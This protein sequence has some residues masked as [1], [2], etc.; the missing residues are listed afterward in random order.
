[1]LD[2]YNNV[3][4]VFLG[5]KTNKKKKKKRRK[6][7]LT[8]LGLYYRNKSQSQA[9]AVTTNTIPGLLTNERNLFFENRILTKTLPRHRGE[10]EPTRKFINKLAWSQQKVHKINKRLL[11]DEDDPVRRNLYRE[12]DE[13]ADEKENEENYRENRFQYYKNIKRKTPK[14]AKK[15]TQKI[16][17]PSR[18]TKLLKGREGKKELDEPQYDIDVSD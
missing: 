8:N 2:Y 9:W 7:D 6:K 14:N 1:M 4:D 17:K 5:Q 10:I 16:V 3:P 13:V 11:I 15:Y 18:K 12:F